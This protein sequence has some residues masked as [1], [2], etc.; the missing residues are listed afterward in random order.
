MVETVAPGCE[1]LAVGVAEAAPPY[2]RGTASRPGERGNFGLVLVP[3]A[4]DVLEV[5]GL[6]R[7]GGDAEFDASRLYLAAVDRRRRD[8]GQG[9]ASDAEEVDDAAVVV[10]GFEADTI[11][12]KP[13]SKPY[14]I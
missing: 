2:C 5:A 6:H 12:E 8:T 7:N 4:R 1:E 13:A 3:V 14:S 9:P 11:R 10:R